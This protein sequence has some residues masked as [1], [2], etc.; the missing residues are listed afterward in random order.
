MICHRFKLLRDGRVPY[1]AFKQNDKREDGIFNRDFQEKSFLMKSH[2]L[3]CALMDIPQPMASTAYDIIVQT[4]GTACM[5]VAKDSMNDA[6]SDI[7]LATAGLPLRRAITRACLHARKE[8][9]RC[10]FHRTPQRHILHLHF[11]N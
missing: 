5:E 2:H 3:I 6:A 4:L 10:A 1:V 9:P 7:R 8:L 11:T